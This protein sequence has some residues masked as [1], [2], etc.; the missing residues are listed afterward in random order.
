MDSRD[1]LPSA[2]REEGLDPARG[3]SLHR[4]AAAVGRQGVPHA[5]LRRRLPQ[6]LHALPNPQRLQKFRPPPGPSGGEVKLSLHQ[7]QQAL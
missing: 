6:P 3:T 5:A 4:P 2:R 1:S 7:S